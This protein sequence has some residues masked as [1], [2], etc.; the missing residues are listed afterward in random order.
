MNSKS[1]QPSPHRSITLKS[2]PPERSLAESEANR[3][4]E[5]KDPYHPNTSRGNERNF[6]IV[7]RFFDEPEAEHVPVSSR[8]GAAWESPARQCRGCAVDGTTPEGTPP[9][10][11]DSR[12]A[13]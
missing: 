7:I 2:C 3:Q 12:I 5:W 10:H 4:T 13:R 11:E 1:Y 9:L 6:S 8:E